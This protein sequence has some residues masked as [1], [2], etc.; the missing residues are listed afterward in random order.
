MPT[1]FGI[2]LTNL[3][4]LVL[5]LADLRIHALKD[6][7]LLRKPMIN[8]L[9][10]IWFIIF[11]FI[12]NIYLCAQRF[13]LPSSSSSDVQSVK[14]SLMSCMIVVASLYWSSW[15]DSIS[16]IASSK[17]YFMINYGYTNLAR[18]QALAGSFRTS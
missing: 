17:V 14:L 15:M 5:K 9:W 1:W 3:W 4:G 13:S 10:F 2:I 11:L 16:A 12:S 7:K 18:E 6:K 8:S